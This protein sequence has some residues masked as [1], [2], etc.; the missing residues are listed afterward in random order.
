M[1]A[2]RRLLLFG[3]LAALLVVGVGGLLVCASEEANP[4][5]PGMTW[6]EVE[7]ILGDPEW[8]GGGVSRMN[9]GWNYKS[10]MIFI[11]FEMRWSDQ[12]LIVLDSQYQ[13][14]PLLDRVRR[15]VGL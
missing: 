13:R 4:I 6:E 8:V 10:G 1:I 15:W 12:Q 11:R 7:Q 2:C 5:Q 14:Y 9:G 3:L